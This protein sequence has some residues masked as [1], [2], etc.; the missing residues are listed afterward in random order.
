M[1]QVQRQIPYGSS[2][3]TAGQKYSQVEFIYPLEMTF[4]KLVAVMIKK[5][6]EWKSHF[7]AQIPLLNG[8]KSCK[9]VREREF[10]KIF[11]AGYFA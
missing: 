7:S 8:I 9:E 6:A 4:S 5:I 10:R 2:I 11:V 1:A 3:Q